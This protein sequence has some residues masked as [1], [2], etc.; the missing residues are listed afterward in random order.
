MLEAPPLLPVG[1]A[2]SEPLRTRADSGRLELDMPH[3]QPANRHAE[4]RTP[5]PAARANLGARRRFDARHFAQ[6]AHQ[7]PDRRL[8]L[9]FRLRVNRL[10]EVQR[11]SVSE[12]L[13]R[14]WHDSTILMQRRE[15]AKARR[16]NLECKINQKPFAP[17]RPCVKSG[18]EPR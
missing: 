13:N 15:D 17:S 4:V 5:N 18:A 6:L 7:F 12:I 11:D 2:N 16:Y 9:V 3:Q 1:G 10:R 14:A 8:Q